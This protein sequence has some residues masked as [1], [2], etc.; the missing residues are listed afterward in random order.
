[1]TDDELR[2][3]ILRQLT[4]RGLS[5]TVTVHGDDIQIRAEKSEAH[6]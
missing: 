6:P 1:M 4:A 2:D 3:K 5:A